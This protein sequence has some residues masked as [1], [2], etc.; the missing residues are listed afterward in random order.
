MLAVGADARPVIPATLAFQD[1]INTAVKRLLRCREAILIEEC[2]VLGGRN[3]AKKHHETDH[4]IVV[5]GNMRVVTF[6]QRVILW[7][8]AVR[9][10]SLKDVIE[11]GEKRILI[12]LV[13]RCSKGAGKVAHLDRRSAI[14][15]GSPEFDAVAGEFTTGAVLVF[16]P[17]SMLGMP[18]EDVVQGLP[19]FVAAEPAVGL[20]GEVRRTPGGVE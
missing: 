16:W 14:V 13:A 19:S 9:I 6:A 12:A 8:S 11:A 3:I 1:T 5:E 15:E 20:L 17:V 10:L 7:P 4:K 2:I 18:G